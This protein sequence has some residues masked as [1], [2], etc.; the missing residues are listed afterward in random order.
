MKLFCS[1]LRYSRLVDLTERQRALLQDW[2]PGASVVADH[3]W[4]LVGTVVLELEVDGDET[5][6]EIEL[7][8]SDSVA[9][10]PAAEHARAKANRGTRS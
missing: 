7:K 2:L 6:L 8:W 1:F 10:K 9:A 3:S 4:G 5:E